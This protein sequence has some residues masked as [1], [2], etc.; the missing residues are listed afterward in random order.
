[1]TEDCSESHCPAQA[2]SGNL[3][4]FVEQLGIQAEVLSLIAFTGSTCWQIPIPS[5]LSWFGTDGLPVGEVDGCE[6]F[7]I[8]EACHGSWLNALC[9]GCHLH[10]IIVGALNGTGGWSSTSRAIA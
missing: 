9:R 2:C 3:Q 1:M 6:A 10:C 5:V 7:L 4:R 8:I